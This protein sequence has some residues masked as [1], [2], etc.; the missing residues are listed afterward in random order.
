MAHLTGPAELTAL[1]VR[2]NQYAPADSRAITD[3][4]RHTRLRITFDGH[5]TVNA[6]IGEFFGS[7]LGPARVR[8]LMFAM[9]DSPDGRA[10]SWWPMPFAQSAVVRLQNTSRQTRISGGMTLT[11]APNRAWIRR[12]APGGGYAYFHAF[13]HSGPTTAGRDWTLLNVRGAGTFV[14]VTMTM[15]GIDPPFYLEGNERAFVDGAA[16]PQILGTGTED[17]FDGGWYFYDQ[18]FS[19]PLSGYTA[20]A[21]RATGCPMPTCK[22]AYRLMVADSVAFTRSLRYEIQ[23]GDRNRIPATYS[24]TAFWYQAPSPLS[25]R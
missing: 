11:S 19:L 12:L 9:D 17:F 2:I 8:A 15:L 24:S 3:A 10:V 18:L 5:E 21:T 25:R 6:P 22:T 1:S 20:H 4:W 14:G 7:G 13:G 23:H 16:Q